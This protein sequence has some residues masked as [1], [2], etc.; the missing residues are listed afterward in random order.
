MNVLVACEYSGIVRDAFKAK[1]HNAWSCDL[2]PTERPGNHIQDDVLKHL[3]EDWDLMIAHPPCTHLA[4]SGARWWGSKVQEQ[5]EGVRFF[6]ALVMAPIKKIALEN[7]VGHLSTVFRKP[8]QIIQPWQF[9]HGET[10]AT[11]LWLYYLPKLKPTKVVDGREA[12]IHKMPP[13][14][15]RWKERSRTYTG[16]AEAMADQWG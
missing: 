13:S 12:R 14:K 16:I 2:L 4:S 10:K 15:D 5:K 11:C 8:D 9:G 3:H 1:G 6:M 7:P